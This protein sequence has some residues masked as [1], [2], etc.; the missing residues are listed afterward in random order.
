MN[1]K[2]MTLYE[3][4][5]RWFDY[6]ANDEVKPIREI[7]KESYCIELRRT[8]K[9]FEDMPI[10]EITTELIQKVFNAAAENGSARSTINH[11][12]LILS[13]AFKYMD[14]LSD[15]AIKNP[16]TRTVLPANAS[17]K[18]VFPL[19]K[20]QQLAI[21]K[22][23]LED[24]CGYLHL[25]LLMTGLRRQELCNLKWADYDDSRQFIK[26][27]ESKTRSGIRTVPLLPFCDDIIKKQPKINEYIFN[28]ENGNPINP[29]A[30]RA[31]YL[32]IRKVTGIKDLTNHVC[33]HTFA[34]RLLETGAREKAI[35]VLLGHSSVAFTLDRYVKAQPEYLRSQ[36][37]LMDSNPL[38]PKQSL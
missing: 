9:W 21:E 27:R 2:E 22:A 26:I 34:T 17:V 1:K 3:L 31:T 8:K 37:M 6:R 28:Q 11:V 10:S 7:T 33:R 32:R 12:R 23:C 36:I 18:D 29:A 16:V 15:M 14:S 4:L 30:L 20:S 24:R 19:T 5:D 35:S 25:F 13:S 38:E